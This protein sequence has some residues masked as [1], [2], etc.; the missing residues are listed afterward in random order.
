MAAYGVQGCPIQALRA[1]SFLIRHW[2]WSV[3][4][5]IPASVTSGSGLQFFFPRQRLILLSPPVSR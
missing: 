2:S 5:R 1:L 4:A 3:V